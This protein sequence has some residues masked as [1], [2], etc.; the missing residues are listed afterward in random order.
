MNLYK[1]N[2]NARL[3][4]TN[5]CYALLFDVT[6]TTGT[7]TLG[8]FF[9]SD[10]LNYSLQSSNSNGVSY[11]SNTPLGFM[12][13]YPTVNS[14][15]VKAFRTAGKITRVVFR[16]DV[17][18][19]G[20]LPLTGDMQLNV[21]TNFNGLAASAGSLKIDCISADRS[22]ILIQYAYNKVDAGTQRTL[23]VSNAVAMVIPAI[24]GTIL[25]ITTDEGLTYRQSIEAL[26]AASQAIN[27]VSVVYGVAA[28]KKVYLPG[29]TAP[30]SVAS[31]K[32]EDVICGGEGFV[33]LGVSRFTRISISST[34][35]SGVL[36]VTP[37]QVA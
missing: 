15:F 21:E 10:T 12:A 8:E 2:Q 23:D 16:I 14:G 24:S 3:A 28:T 32:G 31:F 5:D 13:M 11:A 35:N 18:H 34:D 7:D 20:A 26:Q 1:S 6:K 30:V 17:G 19:G 9:A 36:V 37:V 29:I 25:D 22:P 33:V 4:V 27:E